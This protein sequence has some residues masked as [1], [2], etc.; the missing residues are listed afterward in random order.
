MVLEDSELVVPH[1]L[2]SGRD[3]LKARYWYQ[4]NYPPRKCLGSN[5]AADDDARIL[6][7]Q[8]GLIAGV[9]Y[10]AVRTSSRRKDEF[11]RFLYRAG[12]Y[13]EK[14]HRV[15]TRGVVDFASF[16]RDGGGI[17]LIILF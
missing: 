6:G 11:R 5:N 1:P 7:L 2:F 8:R 15:E 4:G 10:K 13:S 9:R 14:L 12:V 16:R 3:T 17:T